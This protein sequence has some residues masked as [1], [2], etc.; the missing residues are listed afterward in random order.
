MQ[1]NFFNPLSRHI[2][3]LMLTGRTPYPIERTLLTT[4]MTIVGVESFVAG[5]EA[6]HTASGHRLPRY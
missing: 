2:E 6:G 5:A 1:P 3:E 4:G